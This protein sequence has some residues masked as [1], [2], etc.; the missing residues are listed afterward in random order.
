VNR[1]CLDFRAK[2]APEQ[3]HGDAVAM[4]VIVINASSVGIPLV[5][6][7]AGALIGA[8]GMFWVAGLMVGAGAR[9]A[10]GLRQQRSA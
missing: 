10:L 4:R 1:G 2:V 5:S 7:A 8:S 9:L 3:R 6:G